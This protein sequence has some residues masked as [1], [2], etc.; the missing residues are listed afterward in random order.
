[1]IAPISALERT[2][3]GWREGSANRPP[4]PRRAR[5]RRWSHPARARHRDRQ[6]VRDRLVLRARGVFD[7][8]GRA[9]SAVFFVSV[10]ESSFNAAFIPTYVAVRRRE[11]EAAAERL[12]ASVSVTVAI[13]GLFSILLWIFA[14]PLLRL[15]ASGF[16]PAKLRR[17][18]APPLAAPDAAGRRPDC[19]R[20][21]GLERARPVRARRGGAGDDAA[22]ADRRARLVWPPLRHLRARRRDRA[23]RALRDR[24][25]F[26]G[27]VPSRRAA[28]RALSSSAACALSPLASPAVRQVLAQLLPMVAGALI[29]SSAQV[30]DQAMAARSAR[31]AWPR[32]ATAAPRRLRGRDRRAQPR[33]RDPAAVLRDGLGRR[34]RR[35]PPLASH[36]RPPILLLTIPAT[37]ALVALSGPLTTLL[38]QR[39]AFTPAD[40]RL[41]AEVQS[42]Y[43]LRCRFIGRHPRGAAALRARSQPHPAR[44]QR[45]QRGDQS[46]RRWLLMKW[47]GL[48]G[49]ALST[50]LVYAGSAGL[51]WW[52]VKAKLPARTRSGG[53]HA[54][55]A[56]RRGAAPGGA[57]RVIRRWPIS[58]ARRAGRSR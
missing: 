5:H 7:A 25:H 4:H 13:L 37:L 53:K 18:H 46:R 24:D 21:R 35:H 39:G 29:M 58:G 1:M 51:Y 32:S 38:Y 8:F 10:V 19:D 28:R 2:L 22:S 3:R 12:L 57:E 50:S 20:R 36:L 9:P 6:A 43:F 30:V 54:S 40:A 27:P 52:A 56:V 23:G 42:L 14:G 33:H 31:A 48:P 15:T 49:I 34:L 47:L 17:A 55:D 44:H 16:D 41:V 11:G 26:L 45:G